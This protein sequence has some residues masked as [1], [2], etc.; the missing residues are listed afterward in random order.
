MKTKASGLAARYGLGPDVCYFEVLSHIH[1][2]SALS[3]F[4]DLPNE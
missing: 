1:D 2:L 3:L 4:S